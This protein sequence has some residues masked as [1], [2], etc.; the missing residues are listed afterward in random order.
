[1]NFTELLNKYSAE[2]VDEIIN[3]LSSQNKQASGKLKSSLKYELSLDAKNLMFDI[4]FYGIDYEQFIRS[5]R[6]PGAKRPPFKAI[7]EWAAHKGIPQQYVPAIQKG[8]SE[9]GIKPLPFI[10]IV[11][12]DQ[13]INELGNQITEILQAEISQQIK[14]SIQ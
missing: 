7:S 6:R 1:M 14:T 13:K 11:F 12:T 5:G 2:S 4:S 10:D 8:I 3:L 9:S